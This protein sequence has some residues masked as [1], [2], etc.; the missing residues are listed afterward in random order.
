MSDQVERMCRLLEASQQW[1]DE[2]IKT[3]T[4]AQ[5]RLEAEI[6]E[7]R[8][9]AGATRNT[10]AHENLDSNR[11]DVL[12]DR[13]NPPPHNT[14]PG[15][16]QSQAI[17]PSSGTDGRQAPTSGTQGRAEAEPA[18]PA[19]PTTDVRPQHTVPQV[20]HDSP[21]EGRVPSICFLDSWKEDM[22]R[23][24]MQKFS[25]GR[26][27]YA[28]DH[29]DLVS[30]TTEKSPFSEWIMNEPKPRN[31][32]IPSLPTFNGKGDPL[33]HLFQ[34]QQKMAL[35]ANN[36]AIQ[37]KVFSTTFSGPAL[38]WFRQLKA[39]SLN[40][41][42]DLRRSF[43]QQYSTN[44][45]APRTMV[46]LYRIEQGENEH[47]KAYLQR[48]ID[49]VH[50]IHDVD[51]LT[52]ANL[53][54]KRLQ[55]G[56][57]LHEN[58]TMTPPYDMADV[59]TRAEGVFRVLEFQERAQKKTALISAPPANNPPPPARDDKRKRNQ[60][61]HTKEGKRPRQDR[62]PSR[63]PSFEYTVPQEVI[64]EEN[65]DRPIWREPY[66]IN[67]PSDRRDKSRY[68]LFHKDHGHTI[69]EC[70]N[71]NNQIQ[72]LMR[73]G[74]L[75][76]YIKET[77]EPGAS[78]Q[79]TASAPAPPTSDPVHTASDSTPEPLKQVPMIHRIVEPT[80][81]QE[82]ATK[83]HKRMEER[84]KRYKSLGHV[85]NLVTSEERSY[86]ASAVTFTDEDLKG[87]HLPHDDPL[88]IS[89]QVDHCQLGRV[90]ID[91]GSGVDILFW[92]AFQKMGLEEDQI[93]PSTMPILGFNS[94]RVYP[95]GVVRLTVVAAERALPVDFLI[96]DSTTSYN[97][98]MGRGWIH[99]MHGVVSTLHQVMR[100]QSLN[101]RYTVDIKGC[102]KQAKK[103]FLTLKEINSSAS[104]EDSP[105]K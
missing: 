55:V 43:L 51:P 14:N 20:A 79:N 61:D 40:S 32:I 44:R 105:D 35:E 72:A 74:R 52:A 54:V 7:L 26:S 87:V 75:T 88:V 11:S 80:D 100:C 34:F 45:E 63:Y 85:V 65:K 92:E 84:V 68:C 104:H 90:L 21:S 67:T 101:G 69:A 37:C 98:I 19:Q 6:V 62:Q 48:F 56:S 33:N 36:E 99:R 78:R 39:R 4:E 57:L 9:S 13:V 5:A 96:I 64:Y 10:Q 17:P 58:L 31:F 89:L 22:M 41:F 12:V 71:L 93:R 102:Q 1:S 77:G 81:N 46:D 25:D 47:P 70:H 2:A 8:R 49:L 53:F 30:R 59:Q 97:A 24:M 86:T 103:C 16:G 3:L 83:I 28:T 91:G 38:L 73:S 66:K 15:N 18:G 82:H 94:H 23:E 29:L 60:K 76:Q 95:K 42:N 27:A 50:Q